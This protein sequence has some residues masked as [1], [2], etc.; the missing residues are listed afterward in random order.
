MRDGLAN[1]MFPFSL[2]NPNKFLGFGHKDTAK[3]R[4]G[5]EVIF[6]AYGNLFL[7][8]AASQE[9]VRSK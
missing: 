2:E 9:I 4:S 3:S 8:F 5:Q 6:I 7:C 1:R